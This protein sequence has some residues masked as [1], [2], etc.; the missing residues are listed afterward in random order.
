M[1]IRIVIAAA[2]AALCVA[3]QSLAAGGPDPEIA[4]LQVALRSKGMYF[5][6]IDGLAGPM[7]AKGL[8]AFQRAAGLPVT[9]ELGPRTRTRLG[10]LGR[11]LVARR[12][13][14]QGAYGWDVSALQFL[15]ARAGH[16]RLIDLDGH[17]GGTTHAALL[18]FQR[19]RG[20]AADGIAGPATLTSFGYGKRAP[21]RASST[22]A[23][24]STITYIVKPG[25]T[26]AAIASRHKT[27]VRALAKA[28]DIESPNLVL[29]GAKLRL[30]GAV[31]AGPAEELSR[32]TVRGHVDKW[33]ARYGIPV[34]LARALAWQESGFQTNV[35]SSTGAWGPLQIM[36]DTWTFVETVLLGRTVPRTGEGGV[37]VGMALL[38][39][40]LK[41]FGGDQRLA[42]AAW[43]QGE[44][45]VRERGLYKDTKAFVANVLALTGRPL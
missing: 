34:S 26:L 22:P 1:R 7:T 44:K 18:R 41:R 3:P 16:L 36:P 42:L 14:G 37:E 29:E 32:S 17:F 43:Y 23:I 30:P 13:L 25:D 11:P 45:A 38:S 40:L 4:S 20:L 10:A 8:R 2:L 12:V 5:G 33:A 9:G 19:T 24:A 15:L 21:V 31:A 27:T 6:K 28:N 39:H 35:T